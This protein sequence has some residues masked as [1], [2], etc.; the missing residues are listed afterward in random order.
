MRC[1]CIQIKDNFTCQTEVPS[2]ISGWETSPRSTW[3]PA[4]LIHSISSCIWDDGLDIFTNG[5][6]SV[7]GYLESKFL[8]LDPWSRKV[9]SGGW[10]RMFFSILQ[11]LEL[12]NNSANTESFTEDDFLKFYYFF[13]HLVT[14]FN[15]FLDAFQHFGSFFKRL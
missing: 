11:V 4:L 5:P 6:V 2:V 12:D 14:H 7:G 3:A 13:R 15:I 1:N 10:Y 8:I 9:C